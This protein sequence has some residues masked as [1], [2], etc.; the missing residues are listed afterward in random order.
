MT[1]DA[2]RHD[3]PVAIHTRQVEINGRHVWVLEDNAGI[4]EVTESRSDLAKDHPE[5]QLG[6]NGPDRS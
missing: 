3:Q 2:S 5:A 6:E 4:V 1:D